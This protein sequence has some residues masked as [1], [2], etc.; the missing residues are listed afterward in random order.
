MQAQQTTGAGSIE[1][2]SVVSPPTRRERVLTL[3]LPLPPLLA[4]LGE[5]A[6]LLEGPP[7]KN[8][9]NAAAVPTPANPVLVLTLPLP[10][11]FSTQVADAPA[12]AAP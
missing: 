12:P 1:S 8:R 5:A 11:I 4:R 6:G 9:R 10:K 2:K 3:H 7:K